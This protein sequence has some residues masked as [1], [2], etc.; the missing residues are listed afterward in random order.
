[1]Y[2]VEKSCED[3]DVVMRWRW[4]TEMGLR[5]KFLVQRVTM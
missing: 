3:E 5:M 4:R 1:M 2:V